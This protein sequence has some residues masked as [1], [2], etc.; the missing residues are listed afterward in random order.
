M[1]YRIAVII[2]SPVNC[3]LGERVGIAF[4]SKSLKYLKVYFPLN[5]QMLKGYAEVFKTEQVTE[6]EQASQFQPM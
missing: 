1:T 5:I 3:F 2:T 6:W 4:L